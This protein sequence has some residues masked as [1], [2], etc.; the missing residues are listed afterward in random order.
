[1]GD[2]A[3]FAGPVHSAVTGGLHQQDLRLFGPVINEVYNSQTTFVYTTANATPLAPERWFR[4]APGATTYWMGVPFIRWRPM[5]RSANRFRCRVFV[6]PD[7]QITV[8]VMSMS[9]R[10]GLALGGGSKPPAPLEHFSFAAV[11]AA[12]AT[13]LLQEIDLGYVGIARDESGVGTYLALLFVSSVDANIRVRSW[14]VEPARV[15]TNSG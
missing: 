9:R 5:P 6:E 8:G 14:I 13:Y 2:D 12:T 3:Q 15:N 1:M 4:Q 10:P 11:T 7:D